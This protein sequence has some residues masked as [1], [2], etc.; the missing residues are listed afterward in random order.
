MDAWMALVSIIA[1]VAIV[2]VAAGIIAFL[3]HMII[4]AFDNDKK[5]SK[6]KSNENT[7]DYQQ[8]KQL[9]NGESA[10]AEKEYDFESIN[11]AKAE[12]EKAAAE[13]QSDVDFEIED[14]TAEE[15]AK[16]EE[17]LIAQASKPVEE[18]KEEDVNF[19]DL[20][21][22]ISNDVVEEET[23][24][25]EPEPE[26]NDEL[27]KYNIDDI[28]ARI[29]SNE[30]TEEVEPEEEEEAQ[31]E[32]ETESVEDE[33]NREIEEL[34]AQLA[35]VNKKLEEARAEKPETTI[36]MTEEACVER[37]NTLEERLKKAK[38]EYKANMKEYRPI[39]KVMRDLEKYQTKLRR[40]DI[41]VANKKIA[42]YGV[43][44]YVDID[45]ED[46]V[47]IS[48][49][50]ELIEG[51]R[52]SVRHCEEIIEMNKD[53]FPILERTNKILE[54]QIAQLEEDI[55]NTKQILQEIRD[56]KDSDEGKEN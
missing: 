54:D 19:E 37:I 5:V 20:L 14:N 27:S 28:L 47:K 23:T 55:A 41:Q 13:K 17:K 29:N 42:L 12:Q 8:Y 48:N 25:P 52:L 33:K 4:G 40:K 26:Q 39:K 36:D 6:S 50:L 31:P 24:Q 38:A 53:R 35:E 34:K 43:N 22:E 3:G 16:M 56:K 45:K 11:L 32:E 18:D 21:D 49:E 46:A 51:L 9:S 15:P 2:L 7:L 1:I 30:T 44:N 10:T